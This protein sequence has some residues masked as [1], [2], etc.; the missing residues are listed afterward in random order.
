MPYYTLKERWEHEDAL[1]REAHYES[2]W[3][4]GIRGTAAGSWRA[5]DRRN[6]EHAERMKIKSSQEEVEKALAAM[7]RAGSVLE[8]RLRRLPDG[9]ERQSAL[10]ACEDA[11]MSRSDIARALGVSRQRVGQIL[12][13][14]DCPF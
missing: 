11:G 4:R 9:Y 1:R 7:K 10:K 6:A 2:S 5:R 3:A 12:T 14:A 8:D 13:P